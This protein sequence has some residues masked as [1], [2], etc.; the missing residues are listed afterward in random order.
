MRRLILCISLLFLSLPCAGNAA[1]ASLDEL[2]PYLTIQKYQWEEFGEGRRLLEE[3]GQLV[4][5]GVVVGGK[6]DGSLTFRGKFEIFG[7]SVEYDGETQGPDPIPVETDVNYFGMKNQF[8]L[9]YRFSRP[10]LS[11]EPFAGVAHRWWLRD[12]EDSRSASGTAVS[13]YTEVWQ[14]G[15][16]RVGARGRY[17]HPAAVTLFLEAG[18]LYPFYTGNSVDFADSGTTTFHPRGELSAF[19]EAAAQWKQLKLSLHYEGFR[20][21]K[22][23]VKAV[24]SDFFLQPR[25]QADI[26]G[27]SIGWAFR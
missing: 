4:A 3:S 10:A 18:A 22:S 13:G 7:G 24:G 2:S 15:Y 6:T 16:G 27:M 21:S 26:Y 8:D 11:V 5:G 17:H 12:L 25:S 23:P 20:W 9:G 14:T 19:A 1:A